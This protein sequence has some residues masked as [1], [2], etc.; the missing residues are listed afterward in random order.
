MHP[1][2]AT[3]GPNL[4]ISIA[5]PPIWT[6]AAGDTI[7]GSVNRHSHLVAPDAKIALT[8]IGRTKARLITEGYPTKT[9][10]HGN[11]KLFHLPPQTLLRGPIH[12]PSPSTPTDWINIP[13][14]INIPEAASLSAVRDHSQEESFVPLEASC[15]TQHP[16]PGTFYTEWSGAK[17][18]IE[19]YLQAQLRYM[20]NGSWRVQRATAPVTLAHP[21]VDAGGIRFALQRCSIVSRVRSQ[22]LLPSM[23]DVGLSLTQKTQKI[24]GLS[25]VP[26]FSFEVVMGVPVA[27]QLDNSSPIP[28]LI[29]VI[30]RRDGSSSA[31]WDV[32]QRVEVTAVKMSILSKV[33]I[34]LKPSEESLYTIPNDEHVF[35]QH[36]GLEKAFEQ[37]KD[38]IVT[39]AG[40]SDTPVDI[41]RVLRLVLGQNGL[42]SDGKRLSLVASIQPSFVTFNTRLSHSIIW[43]TSLS[44]AGETRTVSMTAEVTVYNSASR[45]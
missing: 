13:F 10:S 30:P 11:W 25:S 34:V 27:I 1:T 8:L 12:I 23:R 7:I 44:I 3:G 26:G 6:Y 37:L 21:N 45:L 39:F 32:V 42:M 29:R 40:P 41:G 19:Y 9:T 5:A 33:E 36:L 16:L 18:C 35:V 28:L 2:Q 24:L 43:Q 17:V 20:R 38:P 22:R 4:N 31:I 15:I 14:S